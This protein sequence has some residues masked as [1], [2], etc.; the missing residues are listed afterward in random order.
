MSL[1]LHDPVDPDVLRRQSEFRTAIRGDE[2]VWISD[3][4]GD[5]LDSA[6]VSVC[7]NNLTINGP[8]LQ[9][10]E[11][12]AAM[13]EVLDHAAAS[14]EKWDRLLPRARRK[15]HRGKPDWPHPFTNP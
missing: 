13:V 5:E 4:N 3:I 7:V 12:L 9:V 11:R 15:G 10:R 8:L 2:L 14:P 6:S 1:R